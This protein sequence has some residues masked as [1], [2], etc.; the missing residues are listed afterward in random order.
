M[1]TLGLFGATQ[2]E[3]DVQAMWYVRDGTYMKDFLVSRERLFG[4]S[5]EGQGINKPPPMMFPPS[6]ISEFLVYIYGADFPAVMNV[7]NN[8]TTDLRN[9]SATADGILLPVPK[10]DIGFAEAFKE[11]LHKYKPGNRL[12]Q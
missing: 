4:K 3:T 10:D 9:M 7:I 2:L 11:W 5:I 12:M 6:S 8:M 1:L